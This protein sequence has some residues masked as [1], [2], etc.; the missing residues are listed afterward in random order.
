MGFV[1]VVGFGSEFVASERVPLAE[2]IGLDVPL[3]PVCGDSEESVEP[4]VDGAA[5]TLPMLVLSVANAVE[6]TDLVVVESVEGAL[7]VPPAPATPT[8]VEVMLAPVAMI[9]VLVSEPVAVS[10]TVLWAADLQ[11]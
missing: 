7:P 6:D 4:G 9:T 5:E 2:G 8:M 1:D 3:T 11:N 10:V